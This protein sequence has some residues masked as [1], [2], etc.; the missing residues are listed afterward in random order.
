MKIL[1]NKRYNELI[2]GT[3]DQR[4]QE[5]H[6]RF[7]RGVI[8]DLKINK[9]LSRKY[10]E[11]IMFLSSELSILLQELLLNLEHQFGIRL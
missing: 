11:D 1:T 8:R 10:I 2:L 3:I 7:L 6:I 9:L 5:I 4:I